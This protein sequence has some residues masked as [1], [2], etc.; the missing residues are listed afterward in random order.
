MQKLLLAKQSS[1][2]C[3]SGSGRAVKGLNNNQNFI[4]NLKGILRT[5]MEIKF[6]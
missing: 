4:L 3:P 2:L 6:I 1:T 5:H